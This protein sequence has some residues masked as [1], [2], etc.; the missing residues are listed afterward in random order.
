MFK[1]LAR[2][3]NY[4]VK[5]F[6]DNYFNDGPLSDEQIECKYRNIGLDRQKGLALLNIE[7]M[8]A[9]ETQYRESDGM[10]SEHLILLASIALLR[11]KEKLNILEIGTFDG[12]TALLL[13]KLFPEANVHTVDLGQRD[14]FD[15]MYDRSNSSEEFVKNRN[16][17]LAL[18]PKITF[19][20]MNSLQLLQTKERYDFIW[21]DGAHGYPI[22]AIDIAN[23]RRLLRA[24][25][26]VL[27]DD[28][29]T[30]KV[31]RSDS[32]YVSN[33]GYE[34]LKALCD[35][36]LIANFDLIPKRLA[37]RYNSR[38]SKKFIGVFR[39]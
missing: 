35:A 9:F 34:T 17:L 12:R 24:N 19:F 2:N 11:S 22:V 20:E 36:E 33:G 26:W 1:R 29:Y 21:I 3:I 16:R 30:S 8:Q 13:S 6:C 5:L 18:S 10:F 23:S 7:L 25:G 27:I 32:L 37:A 4:K 15:D 39:C 14:G 31:K 28:V 38:Q